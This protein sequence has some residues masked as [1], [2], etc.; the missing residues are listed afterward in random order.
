MVAANF[1]YKNQQMLTNRAL[2][3]WP[4]TA[5]WQRMEPYLMKA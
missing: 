3:I 5:I 4:G 1:A 2:F